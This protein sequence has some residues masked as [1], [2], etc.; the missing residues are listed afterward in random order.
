M[1]YNAYLEGNIKFMALC[2]SGK[3][4]MTSKKMSPLFARYRCWIEN[5]GLAKN[6]VKTYDKALHLMSLAYGMKCRH[7]PNP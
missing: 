4:Q 5:Q 2:R 1:V 6:T 7:I 3:C